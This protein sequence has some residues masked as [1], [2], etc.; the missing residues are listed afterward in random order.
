MEYISHVYFEFL[1]R[2]QEKA[3]VIINDSRVSNSIG[4]LEHHYNVACASS[5][6][7]MAF[8]LAR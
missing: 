7:S 4:S 6:T 3:K 8:A 5:S 2:V 1:G